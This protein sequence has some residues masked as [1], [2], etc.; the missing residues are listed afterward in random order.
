M[1]GMGEVQCLLAEHGLLEPGE[2]VIELSKAGEGNMNLALRVITDRRSMILKQARPWVEKYPSIPAPVNRHD[3]EA[4]FYRFI[5][6]HSQVQAMMP[7]LIGGISEA[8]VLLIEDLGTATDMT[9][10]YQSSS[11]DSS[12]DLIQPLVTWLANLHAL[13]LGLTDREE[14]QNLELRSLNHQHLFEV[15]YQSVPMLDLDRITPG[16]ATLAVSIRSRLPDSIQEYGK[17]YLGSGSCLLHGDFYPGSWLNTSKGIYV[18]DPEFC[19][20]GPAEYDLGIMVAHLRFSRFRS[21]PIDA[22]KRAY[23]GIRPVVVDWEQVEQWAAIEILRRLLGVAQLPLV[24]DLDQKREWIEQAM[25]T[26]R[27]S[28]R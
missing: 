19:F 10:M 2:R 28:L 22:M 4:R 20:A 3:H 18:I 16:L 9:S 6:S 21:E 7:R 14:F 23:E 27:P 11:A 5:A 17:R 25:Q 12:H 8:R 26:L 13:P 1:D 24:A 15:P